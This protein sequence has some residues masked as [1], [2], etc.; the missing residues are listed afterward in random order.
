[1]RSIAQAPEKF[2]VIHG[3]LAESR[4]AHFMTLEERVNRRQE[5]IMC[6]HEAMIGG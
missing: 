1:M 2:R 4:L 3:Q 6:S 5:F